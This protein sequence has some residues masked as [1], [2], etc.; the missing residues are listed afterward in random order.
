MTPTKGLHPPERKGAPVVED[1]ALVAAK[2]AAEAKAA[3]FAIPVSTTADE[4]TPEY[5]AAEKRSKEAD[6]AFSAAPVTSLAGALVKLRALQKDITEDEGV[7]WGAQHVRTVTAFLEGLTGAPSVVDDGHPDAGLLALWE[8]WVRLANRMNNLSPSDDELGD[9]LNALGD[10]TSRIEIQMCDTTPHTPAGLV[11]LA[12]LLASFQELDPTFTDGR[13]GTLSRNILAALE[14]LTPGLV[15]I[16]WGPVAAPDPAVVAGKEAKEA[17][18]AFDAISASRA[19]PGAK[20]DAAQART[21][22][23]DAIFADAPV[24]SIAGALAKMEELRATVMSPTIDPDETYLDARHFKTVVAFL[25]GRTVAAEP[26]PV[27]TLFA[28]WGVINE[29]VMVLSAAIPEGAGKGTP[30]VY[31]PVAEEER[32]WDAAL[33][34]RDVVADKILEAPAT[35]MKG[36]AIKIRLASHY[37]FDVADLASLYNT[38]SRDIDYYELEGGRIGAMADYLI[39]ALRDAERLAG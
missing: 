27:V 6:D 29:E 31:Q 9:E 37:T 26:D 25:E 39:S 21:E 3:W 36:V 19:E 24:T 12:K 14:R 11:V 10:Q 33:D 7:S 4:K 22:K 5:K 13:D 35:S 28:E 16:G 17:A 23:A 8:E 38:P 20:F 32:E 2:E 18:A 15:E 34:R 1:P 30:G